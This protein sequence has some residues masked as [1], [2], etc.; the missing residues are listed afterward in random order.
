MLQIQVETVI[1][2]QIKA[3]RGIA[4]QEFGDRLLSKLYPDQ[5]ISVRAGGSWGDLKNDGYCH[6]NRTFFHFYSTSQNNVAALK[7]K[8]AADISGCLTKQKQVDR[9]VFVTNDSNLGVIEAF[10]DD[11]RLKHGISIDTWGPNRLV[12]IIRVLPT[13]DIAALFNMVIKHFWLV[14]PGVISVIFLG[15]W[16]LLLCSFGNKCRCRSMGDGWDVLQKGRQ[17]I[18]GI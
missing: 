9:I 6:V 5:Y 2:N 3:Y 12:E 16:G 11:L 13:N 14:L 18:H 1:L 17:Y 10:I 4:F 8:I 15:H 7:A